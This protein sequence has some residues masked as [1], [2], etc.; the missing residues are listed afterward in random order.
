MLKEHLGEL[1]V[2][3]EVELVSWTPEDGLCP[4]C[5]RVAEEE[6]VVRIGRSIR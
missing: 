2:R 1:C 6:E 4:D 3:I 5:L